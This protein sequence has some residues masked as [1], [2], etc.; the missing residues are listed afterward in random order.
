MGW[1]G[2]GR[3]LVTALVDAI[4][5]TAAGFRPIRCTLLDAVNVGSGVIFALAFRRLDLSSQLL[6]GIFI[7]VFD[8]AFFQL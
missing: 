8:F 6:L 4:G 3:S 1:S 5:C 2:G 7:V